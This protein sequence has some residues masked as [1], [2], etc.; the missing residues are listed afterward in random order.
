MKNTIKKYKP[1]ILVE[2]HLHN[3][4]K[5]Y[6]KLKKDYDV[7]IYNLKKN[8]MINFKKNIIQI[9]SKNKKIIFENNEIRNV[10]FIPKKYNL[11][12]E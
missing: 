6:N 9:H 10:Y 8:K 11:P 5:I 7:Y 1:I 2:Y 12:Y 3:F 4:N